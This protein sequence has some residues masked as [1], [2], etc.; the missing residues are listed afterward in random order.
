M[1]QVRS[2]LAADAR[3]TIERV[4]APAHG[5]AWS[6]LYRAP[7]HRWVL[8]G[9]GR[10]QWRQGREELVA[11]ALTAFHIAGGEQYQLRGEGA[12][13]HVVLSGAASDLPHARSWR[14]RPSDLLRLRL[15]WRRPGGAA[16]LASL[17]AQALAHAVPSAHASAPDCVLRACALLAH[18]PAARWTLP[19]LA[20]EA[21]ASPFHLARQFRRHV[22][23]S[24]HQYLVRLRIAIGLERLDAGDNQ[25][26]GLAHELGFASQ[27]HFG[28]LF[29]REVGVS[30]A[31]A[32]RLLAAH[33]PDS[34]DCAAAAQ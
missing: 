9:G 15:A 8:P 32:R 31:H 22:G 21:G 10:V 24:I 27:S 19:M 1:P 2:L 7:A 28:A 33:E 5:T 13:S 12:R 34:H 25:L 16:Q 26:A 23:L 29:R 18:D 17:V 14:L 20:R 30:P 4:V 11:D 3:L 6:P